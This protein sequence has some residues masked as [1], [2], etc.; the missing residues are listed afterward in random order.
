MP[1]TTR[2]EPWDVHR[3]PPAAG[4]NVLVTG[5][6]AGVGYFVAEQLAD[7]GASVVLGSRDTAQAETAAAWIRSQVPSARARALRLDHDDLQSTPTQTRLRTVETAQM[8]FGLELH[9][10]QRTAA[11]RR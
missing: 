8:P 11:A 7:A 9:R 5:G 4:R 2:T 1:S 10:R 6:N 3:L